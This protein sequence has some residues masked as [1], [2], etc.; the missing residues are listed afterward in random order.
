MLLDSAADHFYLLPLL[1]IIVG[2][3]T[4][5]I[6]KMP[7]YAADHLQVEGLDDPIARS[8]LTG[9]ALLEEHGAWTWNLRLVGLSSSLFL[10]LVRLILKK[11][12]GVDWYALIHAIISSGGAAACLYL[13][14]TSSVRLTGSTE[15]FRA[16]MCQEPLTSLHRILPAITMGYALF[17]LFDGLF[18]SVD[19]VLHGAAT[20]AVMALFVELNAPQIMAPMLLMETSTIFLNMTKADFFS[21]AVSVANLACFTISFF[22]TRIVIVPI[23]WGNLMVTLWTNRGEVVFQECYPSYFKYA[24]F[25]FGM[26]YNILNAYWFSK[27]V[28][29]VQRKMKGVEKHDEQNDL[30]DEADRN[31][32]KDK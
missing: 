25:L 31:R 5:I 18:I 23:V 12:R 28:R 16:V 10:L 32:K 13:D 1:I 20:L 8:L 30:V 6:I 21:P 27:I 7:L 26:F 19:F 15:P 22:L 9:V 17:D 11:K 4:Y 29:K 14:N 24:C 3:V 2:P